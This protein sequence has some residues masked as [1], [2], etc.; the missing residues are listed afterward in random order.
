MYHHWSVILGIL[1]YRG[2]IT[3]P[4]PTFKSSAEDFLVI[5][6]KTPHTVY[7]TDNKAT[8]HV[9]V[10]HAKDAAHAQRLKDAHILQSHQQYV[11]L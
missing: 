3:T 1:V 9:P 11:E 5:D 7:V 8:A 2:A 6:K 4:S 10:F